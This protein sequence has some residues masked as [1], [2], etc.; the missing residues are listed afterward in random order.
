M[1]LL[2]CIRLPPLEDPLRLELPDGIAIEHQNLAELAQPALAPLAPVFTI[3]EV[4]IAIVE[5]V[6]AI[7]DAL[8]PP[9]DP[10]KITSAISALEQ[11]MAKLLA[12]VPQ[13][14]LPRTLI[15]LIDILLHE[16]RRTRLDLIALQ[17]RARAIEA[18]RLK[19]ADLGDAALMAIADCAEQNLEQEADNLARALAALSGLVTIIGIFSGMVGGP[20]MPD[21][22]SMRGQSL[23]KVLEP[24]DAL[25]DALSAARGVIPGG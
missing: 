23:D 1:G 11:K 7:P 25:I 14:S 16:L 12:L 3:I 15:G 21:F 9:P 4:V 5:A 18:S 20:E 13:L 17:A 24:I 19:G 10:S 2:E 22:S 8:G 6:K